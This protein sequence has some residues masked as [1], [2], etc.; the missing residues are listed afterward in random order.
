M[1]SFRKHGEVWYYR[2][3]DSTGKQVERKGHWDKKTAQAM[4]RKAEDEAAKVRSGLIDPK[5]VAYRGHE[6]KSLADHIADWQ[7]DL[8]AKG[9]TP[10]HAENTSNRARRLVAVILKSDLALRDHRRLAP[11]DRD[12][13]IR[14]IAEHIKAARLS[15]LNREDVQY[16]IAQLKDAG[17]SLQTC[18]HYRAS[19]KAFSKWCHDTHRTG[20]TLRGVKGS[21]PRKTAGTI[22]G[23]SPSMNC[24]GS[25]TPPSAAPTSGDDRPGPG[26]L[27]PAG[28]L[29]RV[30]LLGDRQHPARVV[31]L[32]GPQ[33]HRSAAL[34]QERR[35][36]DVAPP[37]RPGGRSGR[38]RGDAGRR[39]RP[40]SRCRP[41]RVPRCSGPTWKPPA[42]STR[43]PR[44]CSSTS[45][46][47]DARRRRMADA[48][49]VLPRVVQK[50]MRHST[51][52]LTGRYTKPR[53]VD[54]EAAAS[55]LPSLKP[56][57]DKPQILPITGTKG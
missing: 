43:M 52:E 29:D 3:V 34:H 20:T 8:V 49:G 41:T 56:E 16:A 11:D 15:D 4:A 38:L 54:I 37:E 31:R 5:D 12:K 6:A 22:A 2:Y 18:N 57:E 23:P 26:A 28:R 9:F 7:A 51:L 48:A 36:G 44:D 17:R 25:S 30:A 45:I 14:K 47:C 21:T 35:P 42:S 10:K 13:F 32:E 40:S 1:A 55:M 50:M 33:R 19:L 53:A 24:N 46:R 27:L 39:T